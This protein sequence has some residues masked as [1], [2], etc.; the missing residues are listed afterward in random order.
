MD[1]RSLEVEGIIPAWISWGIK[2]HYTALAH[3]PTFSLFFL[4]LVGG[5]GGT[6]YTRET[7]GGIDWFLVASIRRPQ[8]N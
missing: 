3:L 6:I 7:L 4:S 2:G 1:L 8:H 5:V